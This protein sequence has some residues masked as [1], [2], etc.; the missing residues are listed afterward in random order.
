MISMS[1]QSEEVLVPAILGHLAGSAVTEPHRPGQCRN[2]QEDELRGGSS[3][4]SGQT[5]K[6]FCKSPRAGGYPCDHNRRPSLAGPTLLRPVDPTADSSDGEDA[7]TLH[8]GVESEA[9]ISFEEDPSV[10]FRDAHHAVHDDGLSELEDGDLAD[11]DPI[12]SE[13]DEKRASVLEGRAH[14]RSDHV[15]P[16]GA[17]FASVEVEES[18]ASGSSQSVVSH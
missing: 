9:A 12:L 1:S 14:A 17:S 13:L 2:D 8:R 16:G 5:I 18:P 7:M 6:V 4:E 11:L 3:S 15:Q 10:L